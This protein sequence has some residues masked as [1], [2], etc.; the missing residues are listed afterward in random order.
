MNREQFENVKMGT[1]QIE[2]VTVPRKHAI[3][4]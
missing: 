3:E 4:G 1:L 2:N